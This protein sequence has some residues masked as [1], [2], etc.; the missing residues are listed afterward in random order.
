MQPTRSL[1]GR[2]ARLVALAACLSTGVQPAL[3][4][5]F[6]GINLAG[7]EFGTMP[8]VFGKE[9]TYPSQE[10]IDYF[11]GKGFNTVRLPFRWERIQRRLNGP[12]DREELARLKE[13]VAA[14]RAHGQTVILDLHNFARYNEKIIGTKDVPDAALADVWARLA[15]VFANQKGVVFGL[16]NEPF[17]MPPTA[18]LPPANAAIAAIRKT[19]AKNLVLVP[20]VS[21]TGAHSWQADIEGSS[22]AS[23]MIDVKDTANN[24]AFEVHQYLDSDFSGTNDD[25]PRGDDAAAALRA[26]TDWFRA[27]KT[28]GFLGEFGGSATSDCMIGLARMVDV[29]AEANDVWIGW[30]YWA[31]GDWWSP[32][33]PLNIQPTD[34]GD[35]LQLKALTT[36]KLAR[37]EDA[38]PALDAVRSR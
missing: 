20:G 9:Y 2:A 29:M 21:W 1:A 26:M 35:R 22:N 10:T 28:R 18:W 15:K 19:G 36:R 12:L 27:N 6:N 17:D 4:G 5:C 14:M 30:T 16:M 34:T 11:A 3:A 33:E 23:T 37:E 8:G 7:A 13:S 25:C 32:D 31:A 38:C 24:L